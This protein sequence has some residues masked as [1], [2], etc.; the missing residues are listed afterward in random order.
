MS[1]TRASPIVTSPFST[2]P[3]LSR[4][5]TISSSEASS[6]PR[7]SSAFV[8]LRG[9]VGGLGC[10]ERFGLIRRSCTAAT[11]RSATLLRRVRGDRACVGAPPIE[12][13]R[14]SRQEPETP[15]QARAVIPAPLVPGLCAAVQRWQGE[16]SSYTQN[17][18]RPVLLSH[19]Y[20]PCQARRA[21]S[22][23]IPCR[24]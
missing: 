17:P 19:A 16:T 10:F 22:R 12:T 20:D 3:L 7:I 1:S 24:S 9:G 11:V 4:L 8:R 18:P 5:S 14:F 2:T 6:G 15:R 23:E 13:H 21:F